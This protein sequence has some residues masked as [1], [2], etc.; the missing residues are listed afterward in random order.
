MLGLVRLARGDVGEA[1]VEFEREIAAGTTQ[2]YAAEFAMNAWGGLGFVAL[3]TRQAAEAVAMFERGLERYP[4]HTRLLTGL[5]A[6]RLAQG[7][8]R[9]ADDVFERT[10]AAVET[11]HRNGRTADASL[12]EAFQHTVRGR[13]TEA[14]E[15]LRRLIERPSPPFAG[16]TIP[17]EPL[18]APL[19]TQPGF[20]AV[21]ARLAENA[22]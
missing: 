14:F 17:I 1:R 15:A 18:L 11:L 4:D 2:L 16:W 5:A 12:A 22:R 9:A 10:T 21:A 20:N 19:R 6:A 7:D 13:H 8:M 3:H